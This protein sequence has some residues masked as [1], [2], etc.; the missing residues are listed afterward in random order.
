MMASTQTTAQAQTRPAK[1]TRVAKLIEWLQ[2]HEAKLNAYEKVQITFNCA[3]DMISGDL[4]Q[5]FHIER[6]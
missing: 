4:K 1:K 5:T 2:Q 6:T 3:G